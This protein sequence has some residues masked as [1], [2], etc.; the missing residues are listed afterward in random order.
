[1]NDRLY[2]MIAWAFRELVWGGDLIGEEHLPERGPA[3][4]VANHL[5][6]IGPIAVTASLPLRLYPWVH[7]DMLD[8]ERAPDYLRQDFVEP[9]LHIPPPISR[10]VA[11][12]ISKVHVPFLRALG[13]IPVYQTPYAMQETFR[14][15]LNLL[16]AG[17]FLAIFPEDARQP[18]D[19]R[20]RLSPFKKGFIRL[21]ELYFQQTRQSLL[22]Y[23][24]TVHPP[25]LTVRV[26]P[27]IGYNPLNNPFQ[28]Q[29]RIKTYL[30]ETI[31]E[32]YLQ[33][34]SSRI[35]HLPLASR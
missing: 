23:P 26:G 27:A 10:W 8:P 15:S 20:S 7:A 32:M 31:R 11:R 14:L 28:E 13:S 29:M 16:T 1:M 6:S 22:F 5:G 18:A 4:F 21:G 35:L 17:N 34:E 2:H 3:V 33:A 24:V 12:I 19:L 25:T 9:Q 30:E